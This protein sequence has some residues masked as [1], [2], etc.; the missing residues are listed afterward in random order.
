MLEGADSPVVKTG[1]PT[2]QSR[3]RTL[4]PRSVKLLENA[5]LKLISADTA[6]TPSEAASGQLAKFFNDQQIDLQHLDARHASV[7][8]VLR[9]VLESMPVTISNSAI[10]DD[11]DGLPILL[12]NASL[13]DY[14]VENDCV[15][16]TSRMNAL[17]LKETR[18]YSLKG[19]K[20]ITPEQL[21]KVIRQSIHPWSWRSQVDDLGDQMKS[22]AAALPS[23]FVNSLFKTSVQIASEETGI[24]TEP[25]KV[26]D[27]KAPDA[28]ADDKPEPTTTSKQAASDNVNVDGE[29]LLALGR[30]FVDAAISA[31]EMAH[32][33][34][35]PTGTIQVLPGKLV[36]TQSQSAHREIA[37]LL[38]QLA[39][40]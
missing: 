40:E 5:Q 14:V 2:T 1:G 8:T 17:M 13:L 7:A 20:E 15:L 36:I 31:M 38:E 4:L 29:E 25:V 18:V 33:A 19:L 12:T 37:D 16:I 9:H 27:A 35:T 30:M 11:L 39:D 24:S 10:D 6:G 22:P 34:E 21:S 23:S 26:P 32:Y 3:I 28:S